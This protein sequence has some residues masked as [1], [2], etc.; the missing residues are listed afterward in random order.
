MKVMS[1]I[2][3][4]FPDSVPS[5]GSSSQINYV[6]YSRTRFL[7]ENKGDQQQGDNSMNQ[8]S[9]SNKEGTELITLTSIV[10]PKT[11]AALPARE[12]VGAGYG[13]R[14]ESKYVSQGAHMPPSRLP[15]GERQSKKKTK[16]LVGES[17][18]YKHSQ[19][20]KTDLGDLNMAEE[21]SLT[22]THLNRELDF[23]ELSR[24]GGCLD[25]QRA[26]RALLPL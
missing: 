7:E 2:D 12:N 18:A 23:L 9:K 19:M 14:Y 10:E 17:T 8:K 11:F 26:A 21:A 24:S 3:P 4:M 25:F 1:A 6:Y 16:M 22:M 13:Q 5:W 20:G 15:D